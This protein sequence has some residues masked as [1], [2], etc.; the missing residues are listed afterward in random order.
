MKS[1]LTTKITIY[2][3]KSYVYI[4]KNITIFMQNFISKFVFF[5]SFYFA[6]QFEFNIFQVL[7]FSYIK[8]VLIKQVSQIAL[9]LF[10]KKTAGTVLQ[11]NKLIFPLIVHSSIYRKLKLYTFIIVLIRF[12]FL[13]IIMNFEFPLLVYKININVKIKNV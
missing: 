11:Q 4:Q 7:Y 12:F 2:I 1:I 3:A 13:G 10:K 9:I 8:F 6:L 5:L